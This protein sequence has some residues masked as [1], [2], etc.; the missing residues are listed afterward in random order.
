MPKLRNL[1]I[2][3]AA[4][5]LSTSAALA[6]TM[7]DDLSYL[8]PQN[9][10]TPKTDIKAAPQAEHRLRRTHYTTHRHAR[11]HGLSGILVSLFH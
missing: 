1:L 5:M 4:A 2:A 8:P 11:G 6:D 3:L 7:A 10:Q 9:L